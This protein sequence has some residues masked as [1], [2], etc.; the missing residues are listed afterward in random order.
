MKKEPLVV[1]RLLYQKITVA[2][3]SGYYG[4]KTAWV[5]VK[6]QSSIY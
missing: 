2:L 6:K 1:V 5:I 4:Q 3:S